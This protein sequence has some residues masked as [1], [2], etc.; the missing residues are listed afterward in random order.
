MSHWRHRPKSKSK[1]IKSLFLSQT[2][3]SLIKEAFIFMK[4]KIGILFIVAVAAL[5]LFGCTDKL[6][7]NE[8]VQ[9]IILCPTTV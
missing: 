9:S 3:I 6:P 8:M 7:E 1:R 5:C 2:G 4:E